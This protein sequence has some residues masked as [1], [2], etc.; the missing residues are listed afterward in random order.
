[1]AKSSKGGEGFLQGL[2]GL[3]EKLNELAQTGQ[4]LKQSG[5]IKLP[6]GKEGKAVYGVSMKVGIGGEDVRVQPF[7]NVHR[8]P[9][10]G[11]TVIDDVREPDVEI[12]DEGDY[13]LVV[14]E[15][16][17]ASPQDV[18]VKLEDKILEL[19]AHG[20]Q[21]RYRKRTTLPRAFSPR[22]M[23]HT[24]RNGILEIRLGKKR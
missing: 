18:H 17:G 9:Q 14:A 3:L 21:A 1:M 13:V 10:T 24:C 4:E 7:G 23:T 22:E 19:E 15:I 12:F 2:S 11:K 6:G 16:P 8:D 20:P 5:E